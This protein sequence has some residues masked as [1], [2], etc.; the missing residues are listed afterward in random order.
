MSTS[1]ILRL[2]LIDII[3]S[4]YIIFCRWNIFGQPSK[5]SNIMI[6]CPAKAGLAAGRANDVNQ[7]EALSSTKATLTDS[8]C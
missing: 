5:I 1:T 7:D 2:V 4:A 6:G 8:M 3:H